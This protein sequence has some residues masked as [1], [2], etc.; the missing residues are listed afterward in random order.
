V[1][2]EN[3]PTAGE[4]DMDLER[5]WIWREKSS[6]KAHAARKA[7]G[8]KVRMPLSSLIY[9]LDHH[10]GADIDQVIAAETNVK[11]VSHKSDKTKLT[12]QKFPWILI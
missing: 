6:K 3:W 5:T 2:L 8:I 10:L 12:T 4:V 9:S 11:T 1:H 7:Q